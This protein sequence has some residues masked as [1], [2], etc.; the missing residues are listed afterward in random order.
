MKRKNILFVL[1]LLFPTMVF[2]S[3]GENDFPILAAIG[4]EAFV[5][6][7]MS[8]FVLKPLSEIF[9]KEDSKKLFWKLFAYRVA[10][11]LFCDIFITT[12]IAIVDFIAVFVGAFIVVPICSFTKKGNTNTTTAPIIEDQTKTLSNIPNVTPNVELI[13]TKCKNKLSINDNFCTNCG[14][15]FDKNNVS[16]NEI[17]TEP[18]VIV[19]PESFDNIYSLSD[20]IMLEEFIKR[21]LT[22]CGIDPNTQTIPKDI[23]KRKIIFNTIFCILLFVFISIIFFHFPISTYTI[24]TVILIIFFIKTRK[25]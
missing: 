13:C 10:I 6:I 3:S 12:L 15:P 18:K 14:E 5:S 8:L 24:G 2:A 17:K 20:D 21:E 19:N 16:V 9:A 22:K 25:Y 4:M 7:H 23:L 1:L 11:L